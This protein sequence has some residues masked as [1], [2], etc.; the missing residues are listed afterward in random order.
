[1][2]ETLTDDEKMEIE[3]R[4]RMRKAIEIDDLEQE[5]KTTYVPLRI[6]VC[7]DPFW[8]ALTS[9]IAHYVLG[10]LLTFDLSSLIFFIK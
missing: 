4:E 8:H 1:M 2:R 10:G 7:C 6:S 3:R 5:D 9:F